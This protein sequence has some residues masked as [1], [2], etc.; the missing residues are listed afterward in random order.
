MAVFREFGVDVVCCEG[1]E[2]GLE[3]FSQELREAMGSQMVYVP[4]KGVGSRRH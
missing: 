3:R 4:L 2:A 1:D